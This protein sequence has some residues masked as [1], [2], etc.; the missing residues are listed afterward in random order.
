MFLLWFTER[1]YVNYTAKNVKNS[2]DSAVCLMF[3]NTH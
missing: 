2:P 3:S 1:A